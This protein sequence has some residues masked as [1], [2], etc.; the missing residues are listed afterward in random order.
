LHARPQGITVKFAIMKF[1]LYFLGSIL[2]FTSSAQAQN[3]SPRSGF[4]TTPDGIKIH[5]LEAGASSAIEISHEPMGEARIGFPGLPRAPILFIP[6]WTMPASIWQQQLDY[7][8]TSRRVIAMDP[9]GQ[10]ESQQ[11][12]EGL[13]PAARARD[14]KAVV[15]QLHLAPVVLVGWSMAVTE[16]AAYVDQFGTNDVSAIVMI[17]DDAGGNNLKDAAGNLDFIAS[18]NRDRETATKKLIQDFFFKKQPQVYVDKMI[19]ASLAVPTSTA[20]AL[21]VGKFG[22][23]YRSTLPKF[24]RPTLVCVARMP[25]MQSVLD[26]QKQIPKSRLEIFEDAGHA[27]F[28]DEAQHF[29]T[30]V[31][32]FLRGNLN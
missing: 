17:D 32:R 28:V 5:Y 14:I 12:G 29:N 2:L 20:V 9:R 7:F 16:V 25:Y 1:V 8:S 22:A 31:D 23:D 4:I 11:A 18:M 19:Q 21:L 30:I 24:N 26:M 15:D 27:L 10:G 6:G 3:T 13:N